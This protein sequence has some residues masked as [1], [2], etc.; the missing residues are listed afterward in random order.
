MPKFTG[1]DLRL[2]HLIIFVFLF[3]TMIHFGPVEEQQLYD[4]YLFMVNMGEWAVY[5]SLCPTEKLCIFLCHLR[6]AMW[7]SNG[8]LVWS[9]YDLGGG[10]GMQYNHFVFQA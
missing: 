9:I 1:V 10:G 7:L 8:C 5:D 6:G 3:S 2:V 4:W